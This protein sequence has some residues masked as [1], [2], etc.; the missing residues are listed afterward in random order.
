MV[1]RKK[2]GVCPRCGEATG[3]DYI[4]MGLPKG[5]GPGYIV[6]L[7]DNAVLCLKEQIIQYELTGYA[8]PSIDY[9][10]LLL[11][12]TWPPEGDGPFGGDVIGVCAW[13]G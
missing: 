7:V 5:R 9:Q 13:L 4:V 3:E 11:W 12:G 6:H 10:R 1:T 2:K 8:E